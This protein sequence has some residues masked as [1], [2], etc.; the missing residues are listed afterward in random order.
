MACV[1]AP[2]SSCSLRE[3]R[4]GANLQLIPLPPSPPNLHPWLLLRISQ[5]RVVPA[6]KVPWGCQHGVY[7]CV[8]LEECSYVYHHPLGSSV[9]L[10][11]NE[12]QMLKITFK[13]LRVALS[14]RT[15]SISILLPRS[16]RHHGLG[17]FHLLATSLGTDVDRGFP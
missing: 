17:S 11:R 16:T 7:V 12:K 8:H 3:N 1:P 2:S 15:G 6:E 14:G 9:C 10:M 13:T 4:R 5:V